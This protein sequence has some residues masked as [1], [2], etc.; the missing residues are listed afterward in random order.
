MSSFD[1]Y[2]KNTSQTE[3]LKST[4]SGLFNQKKPSQESRPESL[5]SNGQQRRT[6]HAT[7]LEE[8]TVVSVILPSDT[9]TALNNSLSDKNKPG[10]PMLICDTTKNAQVL[11]TKRQAQQEPEQTAHSNSTPGLGQSRD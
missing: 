3:L 6:T 11:E 7:N 8:G 4:G 2:K 10:S 1:E 5:V 9:M